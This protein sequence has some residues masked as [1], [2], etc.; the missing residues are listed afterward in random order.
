[1]KSIFEQNGGTYK[2]VGDYYIPN[3]TVSDTNNYTIGKYSRLRRKFL[4]EH[5]K[6]YYSYLLI[7]GKYSSYNRKSQPP[8]ICRG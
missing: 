6:P 7:T 4:K 2:K 1:M 8:I 3:I 5:H